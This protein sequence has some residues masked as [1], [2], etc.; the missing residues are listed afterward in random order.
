MSAAIGGTAS[1]NGCHK[2]IGHLKSALAVYRKRAER[3]NARYFRLPRASV[4]P[5]LR[6]KV[7]GIPSP[8]IG[9][10]PPF[11]DPARHGL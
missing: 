11:P 10:S 5:I 9:M 4:A 8:A 1:A 3:L 2:E 6:R 7:I